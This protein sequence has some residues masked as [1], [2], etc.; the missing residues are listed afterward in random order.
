LR[1]SRLNFLHFWLDSFIV[2]KGEKFELVPG[3]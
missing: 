1:S 2:N 3:Y